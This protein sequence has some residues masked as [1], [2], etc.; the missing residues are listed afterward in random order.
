MK[1]A[2]AVFD[3]DLSGEYDEVLENVETKLY[4]EVKN[5]VVTLY[6]ETNMDV[7]LIAIDIHK[8]AKVVDRIEK[9]REKYPYPD[10]SIKTLM[11]NQLISA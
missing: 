5:G 11:K 1:R 9:I 4:K 2:Y 8:I 10:E 3:T 7:Y 6:T